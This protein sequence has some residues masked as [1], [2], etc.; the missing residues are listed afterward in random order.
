MAAI[1]H[2]VLGTN[3]DRGAQ[4]RGEKQK[5]NRSASVLFG[6]ARRVLAS[7][8]IFCAHARAFCLSTIHFSM[9]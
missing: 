8:N 2:H 6:A 7:E 5:A 4:E 1:A 9:P 3:F